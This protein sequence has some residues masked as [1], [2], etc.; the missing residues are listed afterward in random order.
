MS[1]AIS[2]VTYA[3][4]WMQRRTNM[5]F[6][7]HSPLGVQTLYDYRLMT[8]FWRKVSVDYKPTGCLSSEQTSAVNTWSPTGHTINNVYFI[9]KLFQK[10]VQIYT[11]VFLN[12]EPITAQPG[13]SS[14]AMQTCSYERIPISAGHPVF[15]VNW[16][17]DKFNNLSNKKKTWHFVRKWLTKKY[18]Y[19]HTWQI[20]FPIFS[21]TQLCIYYGL[22]TCFGPCLHRHQ[23]TVFFSMSQQPLVGQSLLITEASRSHSRHTTLGKTPLDEWSARR[24]DLYLTTHNIHKRQI[25]MPQAG[26]EHRNLS[27]RAAAD[28]RHRQRGNWDQPGKFYKYFKNKGK[29]LHQIYTSSVRSYNQQPKHVANP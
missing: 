28:P 18:T 17:R 6:T 13:R 14:V 26:F 20:S 3:Y 1:P 23:A 21:P 25:S 11:K 2:E 5:I 29:R 10:C 15:M 7:V 22:A 4:R 27:K 12:A 16:N 19:I 8:T 24:R 9:H